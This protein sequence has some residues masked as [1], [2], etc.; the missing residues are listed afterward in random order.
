MFL[1][2]HVLLVLSAGDDDTLSIS[3]ST[4]GESGEL[5]DQHNVSVRD[6]LKISSYMKYFDCCLYYLCQPGHVAEI[7]Y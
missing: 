3:E 2:H 6:R 5:L 7:S 1:S 4:S